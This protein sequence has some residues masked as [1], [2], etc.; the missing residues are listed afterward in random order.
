M[1]SGGESYKEEEI[2]N[3]DF[4]S[5]WERRMKKKREEMKL[6]IYVIIVKLLNCPSKANSKLMAN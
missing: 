6:E 2:G 5:E 4:A 1:I 3:G